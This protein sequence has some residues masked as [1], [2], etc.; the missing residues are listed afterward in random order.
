MHPQES[1][2]SRRW[3][4]GALPS[5]V[6]VDGCLD[7]VSGV[8]L[9]PVLVR[10]AR[11]EELVWKHKRGV[12]SKVRF[13]KKRCAMLDACQLRFDS[14]DAKNGGSTE[15]NVSIEVCCEGVTMQNTRG[16][17]R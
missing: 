6:Q 15:P 11:K 13:C 9:P 2:R 5:V 7:Y 10:A 4:E 3:Q 16:D 14:V 1:R 12:N 8:W 17:G